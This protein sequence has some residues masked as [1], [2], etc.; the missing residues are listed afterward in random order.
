M[1]GGIL[2]KR[3]HL[4]AIVFS[5]LAAGAPGVRAQGTDFLFW[6]EFDSGPVGSATIGLG[7]RGDISRTV[8]DF[9]IKMDRQ[10]FP[11]VM[12]RLYDRIDPVRE[13]EVIA[14]LQDHL[15]RGGRLMINI[16]ELDRMP[17][18]Q[19][20]LGLEGAVDIEEPLQF[21]DTVVY[22]LRFHPAAAGGPLPTTGFPAGPDFG[23]V[24]IPDAS[25]R[26]IFQFRDDLTVASVLGHDGRVIVN[27]WEWSS[28]GFG[29]DV[30]TEQLRW[31]TSCPADLDASGSL[32]LFD[33]LEFQSLFDAGDPRAD[34]FCYDGRLDVFD[35][36]AFFNAFES[37]CP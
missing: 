25:A 33:F 16:A 22:D 19:R 14:A 30:A 11:L 27:G 29:V 23:D 9:L 3:I 32:D 12:I 13:P 15:D 20:F 10:Q 7:L 28:W 31:L 21:A 26:P 36:L 24:L 6:T 5:M 1:E 35:F 34:W 17:N 2:V 8:G 18:M 37:G 4:L